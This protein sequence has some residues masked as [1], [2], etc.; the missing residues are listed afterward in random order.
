MNK[1][2]QAAGELERVKLEARARLYVCEHWYKGTL[3]FL[4]PSFHGFLDD[5]FY[6][7]T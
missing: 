5:P 3:F 1:P 4:I 2:K 7:W 6:A